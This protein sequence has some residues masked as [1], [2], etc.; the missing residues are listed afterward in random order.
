MKVE[1][2]EKLKLRLNESWARVEF[3]KLDGSHR[4]MLCT[5]NF[6]EIPD[7]Q[8]PSGNR[9]RENDKVL[10]VFDLEKQAWRSI[11]IDGLLRWST[12]DSDKGIIGE[13]A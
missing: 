4:S 9:N 5:R 11:R 1:D 3:T 12:A 2:L 7:D 8:K 10:N 6:A 13:V